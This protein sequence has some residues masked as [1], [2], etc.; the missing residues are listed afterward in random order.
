MRASPVVTASHLTR[1][2]IAGWDE[3]PLG[4]GCRPIGGPA[5]SQDQAAGWAPVPDD[6]AVDVLLKAHA[7][8]ATV[9]DTA[10]VYGLGHSQRL[11]G[12]MLAQV[13]RES[14]R[15]T[16]TI[17]AFK[18]TGPHSYASLNLHG[19][20]QQTLENLGD[21]GDVEDQYLDV[22]N[23]HH[24]NFGPRDKYL[25]EALETLQALRDMDSI[26]AVGMPAPNRLATSRPATGSNTRDQDSTARFA[27]LF[28]RIRPDVVWTTFNP[29]SPA[30]SAPGT[31][32]DETDEDIFSFARRQ[33]VAT[34][35]CEP[36]AQG[37][38]TGKYSPDTAFLPGDVRSRVSLPVLEAVQRSLHPLRERFG[39]TPDDLARIALHYCLRECPDSIVLVG[40][41]TTQQVI[42]NYE[43]LCDELSEEDYDV[44]RTAYAALRAELNALGRH[45]PLDAAVN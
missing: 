11:L 38:L 9:F 4:V 7:Q 6:S 31:A 43:G 32:G 22:L 24:T 2:L 8:G 44:I 27:Y 16:C 14:V 33:G 29:L 26:R 20:V 19:Q 39:A 18:G 35:V 13:P 5:I 15:I 45:R 40:S 37:L 41:S 17:G 25:D 42:S 30:P 1:R 34:M 12:R 3:H 23:L 10:D 36:L 28:Q 21:P